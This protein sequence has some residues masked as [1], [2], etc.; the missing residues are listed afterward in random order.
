M[1][2]TE[3]LA[4][5]GIEQALRAEIA[6][7]TAYQNVHIEIIADLQASLTRIVAERDRLQAALADIERA[8]GG[9]K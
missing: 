5:M 4:G 6:R 7:L 3:R 9:G 2:D 8:L 1:S